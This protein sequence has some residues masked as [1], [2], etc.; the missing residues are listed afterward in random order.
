MYSVNWTD[1][2]C[3]KQ[4]HF[5]CSLTTIPILLATHRLILIKQLSLLDYV[6]QSFSEALLTYIYVCMK[7]KPPSHLLVSRRFWWWWWVS[8]FVGICQG[9]T[10]GAVWAHRGPG[11]CYMW[12]DCLALGPV[13]PSLGH[14]SHSTGRP[15]QVQPSWVGPQHI[16][17]IPYCFRPLSSAVYV[18]LSAALSGSTSC[19]ERQQRD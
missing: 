19:D 11:Q 8:T 16:R 17:W 6:T 5:A 10:V 4:I 2:S 15:C 12:T 18:V 1:I 9:S 14:G 3:T 7:S 13:L